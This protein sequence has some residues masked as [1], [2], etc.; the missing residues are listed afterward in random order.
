MQQRVLPNCSSG[1]CS[2]WCPLSSSGRGCSMKMVFFSQ[3]S[4]TTAT[5][6][7][8]SYHCKRSSKFP[9]KKRV[10]SHGCQAQI[11]YESSLGVAWERW[12]KILKILEKKMQFFS[13]QNTPDKS[14]TFR[15]FGVKKR[16]LQKNIL[17]MLFSRRD[18]KG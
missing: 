5:H 11:S 6:A 7:S 4:A 14:P 15:S 9:K 3:S 10:E 12:Q 8:P 2:P 1:S 18:Q 13:M 17:L 16:H